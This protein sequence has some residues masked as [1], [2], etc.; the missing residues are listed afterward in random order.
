MRVTDQGRTR[1]ALWLPVFLAWILL[2]PFFVLALVVTLL[3]DLLTLPIGWR[4]NLTRFL[5]G[6]VGLLGEIRGTEVTVDGV[7]PKNNN[8]SLAFR[9]R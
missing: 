7:D 8:I 3:V 5:F 9:I 4:F 1:F 2:L 6:L